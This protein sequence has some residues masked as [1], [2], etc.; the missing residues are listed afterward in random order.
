LKAGPPLDKKENV[1][2]FKK[3]NKRILK[4]DGAIY[5]K[6]KVDFSARELLQKWKNSREGQLKMS[7]MGISSLKIED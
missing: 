1:E 4:K 5:A 3:A 7:D 6:I 2:Q